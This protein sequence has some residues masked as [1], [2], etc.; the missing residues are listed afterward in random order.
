MQDGFDGAYTVMPSLC[1]YTIEA[2]MIYSSDNSTDALNQNLTT[3]RDDVSNDFCD[4]SCTDGH[5]ITGY[6]KS[7][8]CVCESGF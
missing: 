7:G 6:C 1:L 5:T 4:D 2:N 3:L 8:I